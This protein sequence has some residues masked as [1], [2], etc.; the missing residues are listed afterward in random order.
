[1]ESHHYGFTPSFISKLSHLCFLEPLDDMEEILKKI[2]KSEFGEGNYEKVDEALKNWS[3]AIRY[4]TAS[5]A[6][7]YG[8]FR[9]GPSYPFNLRQNIS[10]PADPKAMFGAGICNSL[11]PLAFNSW[12]GA[13][14]GVRVIEE[15]KSL[16]KMLEYIEKGVSLIESTEEKNGKLDELLNL[17]KF[18][19]NT[20]VTGINTKNMQYLRHK[21]F[22]LETKDGMEELIDTIEKLL[23]DEMENV[24]ATIPLVE[25]DSRLG[26][27]PSMEYVTDKEHLEWKIRQLKYVLDTEITDCRKSLDYIHT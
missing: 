6:D 24:K 8:A 4:Y 22:G 17:G 1:M 2:I 21:L 5:S 10:I 18:I 19:R 12:S 27:E 13:P 16:Q 7:Q 9:V 11:I 23:L 3:E 20:V 15:K 25:K 14:Y 26:W